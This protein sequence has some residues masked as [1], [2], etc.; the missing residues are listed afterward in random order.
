M[1]QALT[2]LAE[3]AD[4]VVVSASPLLPY[5]DALTLSQNADGVIVVATARR[6]RRR[7]LADGVSKLRRVDAHAVG[8]LLDRAGR[9]TD[10][11][12]PTVGQLRARQGRGSRTES[13][14]AEA[15]SG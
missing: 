11:Y 12:E 4:F 8:V 7:Q 6:T 15:R 3:G 9:G 10:S 13:E 14:N 1:A 2:K 5:N